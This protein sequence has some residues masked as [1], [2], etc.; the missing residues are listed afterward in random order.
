MGLLLY[1]LFTADLLASDGI[2]NAITVLLSVSDQQNTATSNLQDALS[3]VTCWAKKWK[4]KLNET[5]STHTTF[6][7]KNY[8]YQPIVI[9]GAIVP[10]QD[11]LKY[12]GMHLDSIL[13]CAES[14]TSDYVL[15]TG[16]S[17]S[18]N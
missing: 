9:N 18:P 5:K 16:Y 15:F 12:L 3:K 17:E 11:T 13:N 10:K 4:T 14:S 1:V 7:L 6:T 2:T 8:S